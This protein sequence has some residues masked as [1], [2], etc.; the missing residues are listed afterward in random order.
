MAGEQ[1]G[2]AMKRVKPK[3]N[4]RELFE[5]WVR[6]QTSYSVLDRNYKTDEYYDLRAVCGWQAWLASK[7]VK[8]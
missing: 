8:R 4:E 7:K 2:E 3:L 1:T 6:Q 5:K